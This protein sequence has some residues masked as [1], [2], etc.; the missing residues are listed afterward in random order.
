ME[1]MLCKFLVNPST[2]AHVAHYVFDEALVSNE[3][4]ATNQ[5]YETSEPKLCVRG[6]RVC[7]DSIP[8][9]SPNVFDIAVASF[10]HQTL[11]H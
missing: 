10:E 9:Q 1:P 5:Q 4:F 2:S 3:T 7:S 11:L 8:L 6:D